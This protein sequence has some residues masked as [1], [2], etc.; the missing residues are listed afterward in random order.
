MTASA[1]V[2][3]DMA[4]ETEVYVLGI[5]GDC[6][7]DDL[8]SHTPVDPFIVDYVLECVVSLPCNT[9]RDWYQDEICTYED[10]YEDEDEGLPEDVS[11]WSGY[12]FRGDMHG[13]KEER[14]VA[15]A[16]SKFASL[17]QEEQDALID[18]YKKSLRSLSDACF[19]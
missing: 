13:T 7:C 19:G 10:L 2:L 3:A 4:A 12:S 5:C 8:F 1:S 9:D 16:L 18:A 6:W 15:S 14:D 17:P 11:Q